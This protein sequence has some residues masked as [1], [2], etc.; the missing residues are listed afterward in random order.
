M[1]Q[2]EVFRLFGTV[3]INKAKAIAD[4]KAVETQ[5]RLSS[6]RLGTALTKVGKIAKVAFA[7]AGIAAA[8]MFVIAIKKAADFQLGMAK[9]KAITGANAEEFGKLTEKA[10]QLGLETAQTM[11]DIAAGM[12]A[13]GRAGFSATE[14]IEAMG[15]AVALAESQ[16]ME[17]ATAIQ[18]TGNVLRG[19]KLPT[20]EAERVANALAATAA[21]AAVTVEDLG[22][23]M[24]YLAPV[25]AALDMPLEEALTV[26]GKLGDAGLR[27]GRATRALATAL[28]NLADPTD[29][30]AAALKKLGIEVFDSSG[31]FIGV[32]ELVAQLEASF[33]DLQY[34]SEQKMAAMGAIFAGAAGEM[35]ILIGE[36]KS[37][38]EAYQESITGTT[39]AFDQQKAMLDTVSGQWQILKGS[40]ELLL[41]TIGSKALPIIQDFLKDSLIPWVNRMTEAAEGSSIFEDALNKVIDAFKW[42]KTHRHEIVGALKA[43]AV[44]FGALVALKIAAWAQGALIGLKSLIIYISSNPLLLAII[45]VSALFLELGRI[46]TETDWGAPIPAL[47]DLDE[48]ISNLSPEV[49]LFAG[50]MA[51]LDKAF[52]KT[53]EQTKS[54]G[55][56]AVEAI[57]TVRQIMADLRKTTDDT[58]EGAEEQAEAITALEE[59]YYELVGALGEA[60]EGSYE[61]A[62]ALMALESF[63]ED[64]VKAEEKLQEAGIEIGPVLQNLIALTSQ[65][66]GAQDKVTESVK[67]SLKTMGD[68]R[69]EYSE[70]VAA[71]QSSEVGSVKYAG[72]LKGLQSQYD[73]LVD[74][75]DFLREHEVEVSQTILD[76]IAALEEQG[77]VTVEMVEARKLEAEAAEE[78]ARKIEEETNRANELKSA[79]DDL[80]DAFNK[81]TAG[82]YEQAL[83]AQALLEEYENLILAGNEIAEGSE[84]IQQAIG[85]ITQQMEESG[86]ASRAW[87]NQMLGMIASGESAWQRLGR[88][89]G[90][91][92][93]GINTENVETWRQMLQSARDFGRQIMDN[94]LGQYRDMERAT[95]DHQRRMADL[96]EKYAEDQVDAVSRHDEQVDDATLA[97]NRRLED[98]Q[99]DFYRRLGDLAADDQEGRADAIKG[100]HRRMEDA[101]TDYARKREDIE[102]NYT[103]AISD[104]K[105][106]RKEALEDEI[107]AYKETQKSLWEILKDI[108]RDLLSALKEELLLKAASALA[109]AIALTAGLNPL[110]I[111]K[112]AEAA[113][114]G[115]GAAGLAIAGFEKGGVFNR[116]TILPMAAVAEGGYPEAYL[117]LSP[118]V[119]GDI[120]AGIVEAAR[121][122]APQ[123]ALVGAA[124]GG[125][126]MQVDMRGLYDGATIIVRDDQDVTRLA[127]ESHD[128]WRMRM[129]GKGWEV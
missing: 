53:T 91:V 24:K 90:A 73:S 48:R 71:M 32:I 64:L 56:E 31:N 18:I 116:P 43:I 84:I 50:Q 39:Q 54:W 68:L 67:E 8:G 10:K 122:M 7:V 19:M 82:S 109:E 98:I 30:A 96:S 107:E 28:E 20:S 6:G 4:L 87:R 22:E 29:E 81:T 86:M 126:S 35:N 79:H 3:S 108:V 47:D 123:P 103:E 44:A 117:P 88:S 105:D 45:G 37:A 14:I 12:E 69:K 101:N 34:T 97:H 16:T 89:V 102:S 49:E 60:K 113:A 15:G 40:I 57:A 120:G 85:E 33:I 114:Y 112:Y 110:A 80:M 38:L 75:A 21:S 78:L 5:G 63:H 36:G 11:T 77:V 74:T 27:G 26:V 46:L 23:S 94:V 17:L 55:Q 41:V 125:S 51:L 95:E 115:A 65:Y 99:T 111:A 124:V 13:F 106:D 52:E 76:Q 72:A 58:T 25:A 100:Y 66:A 128:L 9:V 121:G 118:D 70:L 2:I 83:A 104:L 1:F 127:R 119:L 61:Y 62:Q 92:L 93:H 42:I 129:R 59:K